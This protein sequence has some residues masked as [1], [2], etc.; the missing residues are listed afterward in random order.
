MLIP[1]NRKLPF[2]YWPVLGW[3][4][5]LG[6]LGSGHFI[7]GNRNFPG[8]LA[9]MPVLGTAL[10]VMAGSERPHQGVSAILEL[11]PLQKLGSLSYSWYLWHWPFLIF[12]TILFPTITIGG[13]LIAAFGSLG[14]AA[15]THH[16]VE[17]PIRFHPRLIQRPTFSLALGLAI[18]VGSLGIAAATIGYANKLGNIPEMKEKESA[19][20]DIANM[21]REKCVTL[22]TSSEVKPCQF[23]KIDSS[24]DI[25]LFGDSHAIQW[26][27]PLLQIA[28]KQN[29]KLTTFLKSGCL[30]VD[31]RTSN[32]NK[33]FDAACSAWREES[34]KKIIGLRPSLGILGNATNSLSHR[35]PAGGGQGSPT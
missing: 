31:V 21:P 17:N 22:G 24:T 25:V 23:G 35:D 32:S 16:L 12:A 14:F 30:S 19:V 10:V 1:L 7:V 8:W 13:K 9:L 6:I 34:V 20:D 4:G 2:S 26:F 29:W 11:A 27:N 5:F 3:I 15:V 28:E 18:T 33:G